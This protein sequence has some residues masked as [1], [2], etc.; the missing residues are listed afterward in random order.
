[1]DVFFPPTPSF[2]AL[3]EQAR[4]AIK[5]SPKILVIVEQEIG[6][7]SVDNVED[8][9][10]DADGDD[11][12][13]PAA[14]SEAM[15]AWPGIGDKNQ[16]IADAARLG[17]VTNVP[18]A[19]VYL[20]QREFMASRRFLSTTTFPLPFHY[21]MVLWFAAAAGRLVQRFPRTIYW[22]FPIQFTD[23]FD[24]TVEIFDATT[25]D[26]TNK[27]T[28]TVQWQLPTNVAAG[29]YV[30][31][32]NLV[33]ILAFP[34]SQQDMVIMFE[35]NGHPISLLLFDLPGRLVFDWE[36]DD[37]VSLSMR[38]PP[39][40]V[41]TSERGNG[42]DAITTT[43]SASP[44][45]TSN[46]SSSSSSLS[47]NPSSSFTNSSSSI[48][49]SVSHSTSASAAAP[50][51]SSTLPL[52]IND[53][54][55]D[56]NPSPRPRADNVVSDD[57]S[58]QI[59]SVCS[60]VALTLCVS[61]PFIFGKPDTVSKL[62]WCLRTQVTPHMLDDRVDR[63]RA[64]RLNVH[65][66]IPSDD[67]G[68][69]AHSGLSRQSGKTSVVAIIDDAETPL[70]RH[71]HTAAEA[72]GALSQDVDSLVDSMVGCTLCELED[73][74][75]G[76]VLLFTGVFLTVSVLLF[77]HARRDLFDLVLQARIF[78]SQSFVAVAS[79]TQVTQ[80]LTLV[81]DSVDN[82]MAW[83]RA[84]RSLQFTLRAKSSLI[85]VCLTIN[86]CIAVLC[87]GF[88]LVQTAWIGDDDSLQFYIAWPF[89]VVSTL[90]VMSLTLNIVQLNEIWDAT[91]AH[92]VSLQ[93]TLRMHAALSGSGGSSYDSAPYAVEDCESAPLLAAYTAA[94]TSLPGP[95]S[96]PPAA[97]AASPTT[98]GGGEER[99][100][101]M[102]V[103]APRVLFAHS[104]EEDVTRTIDAIDV[105]VEH[106][107]IHN[108]G[109]RVLGIYVNATFF[110]ALIPVAA[111]LASVYVWPF[112]RDTFSS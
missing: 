110:K 37:D 92:L 70:E 97:A 1:M 42:N 63:N 4:K 13:D 21:G 83:L 104:S 94:S 59:T 30:R 77:L 111:T 41:A 5:K 52:P 46:T 103:S 86:L 75:H 98:A 82:V 33:H 108:D 31:S 38:H 99:S 90:I 32:P 25:S 81:W 100:V 112:L 84:L 74:G 28:Q 48:S 43:I 68:Y 3:V 88:I 72:M 36:N 10:A 14:L 66:L 29:E 91:P 22:E 102:L 64:W 78:M 23:S 19:P 45:P 73:F 2:R 80:R 8:A 18:F 95:S 51:S 6:G 17:V 56:V 11:D 44:F 69:L 34:V 109:L 47:T 7:V 58:F 101:R 62:S 76:W 49:A 55:S 105:I 50:P 24:V 20:P 9:D 71:T 39:A 60:E 67:G 89:A 96:S 106:N 107:A 79:P 85:I 16:V 15:T 87:V 53:G 54:K 57:D 12:D 27:D 93:T 65:E 40:P 35:T 26:V 61:T